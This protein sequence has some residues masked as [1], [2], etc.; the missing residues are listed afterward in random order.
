MTTIIK[1]LVQGNK[2][3][4]SKLRSHLVAM[5]VEMGDQKPGQYDISRREYNDW[6]AL[7]KMKSTLEAAFYPFRDPNASFDLVEKNLTELISMVELIDD[8][9]SKNENFATQVSNLKKVCERD[10]T[11]ASSSQQLGRGF[12]FEA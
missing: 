7:G 3:D 5:N 9:S 1:D 11:N 12:G 8:L 6:S 10:E 2:K 4:A